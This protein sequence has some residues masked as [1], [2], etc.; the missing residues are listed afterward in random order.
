M[1][2][3]NVV[4]ETNTPMRSFMN[5]DPDIDRSHSVLFVA[6]REQLSA[7]NNVNATASSNPEHQH[8]NDS[9]RETHSGSTTLIPSALE[10]KSRDVSCDDDATERVDDVSSSRPLSSILRN[11]YYSAGRPSKRTVRCK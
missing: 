3:N 1:S 11:R 4:N 10:P 7:K 5:T 9:T 8:A 6:S 2:E